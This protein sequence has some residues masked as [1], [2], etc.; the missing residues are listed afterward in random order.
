MGKFRVCPFCGANIDYGETCSC[1]EEK[2][3]V[4]IAPNDTVLYKPTGETVLVCGVNYRRGYLIP[5]EDTFPRMLDIDDCELIRQSGLEQTVSQK[6]KLLQ[7]GLVAY[8]ER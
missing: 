1:Q 2:Y 8:I 6:K 7:Y 4:I 3:R 5:C